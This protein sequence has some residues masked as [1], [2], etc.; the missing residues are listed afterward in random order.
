MSHYSKI[1]KTTLL[2]LVLFTYIPFVEVPLALADATTTTNNNPR[3]SAYQIGTPT[4]VSGDSQV[5]VRCFEKGTF[6]ALARTG[7][8]TGIEAAI[9]AIAAA[10]AT[11]AATAAA[12]V[13]VPTTD[14]VGSGTTGLNTGINTASSIWKDDIKPYF[15]EL[16]YSAGQCAIEQLTSNTISWIKGGFHGSP[17]F[18]IKPNQIFLDLQNSVAN[19]MAKQVIDIQLNDFI[20]GFSN[21]L[22]KSIQLSTRVN[23]RGKFTNSIRATFPPDVQPQRFYQDFSQGGWGAFGAS[24]QTNNN[25]FGVMMLVGDELAVRQAEAQA[26]Q[27]QQLNWSKG[28][29]DLVDTDK[30]YYPSSESGSLEYGGEGGAIYLDANGQ[31]DPTEYDPAEITALQ[32][33]YCSITT[34]GGVISD[35]L[36]KT[37]GADM[38]RLGLADNVDKIITALISKLVQDTVHGVF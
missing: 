26:T 2:T 38:D 31:P 17:S 32:K 10:T 27:Q 22:T 16:A 1:L 6:V 13:T 33:Q 29:I 21:N 20:P 14:P 4:N 9:A 19:Q 15:D 3:S 35:Q 34:P 36:T 23:A 37:L 5:F 25:P 18:A 24:L 28:Y 8:Q 30:C 12:V 11:G 7:I